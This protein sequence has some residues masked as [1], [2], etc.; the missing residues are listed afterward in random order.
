MRT[1]RY[2]AAGIVALLFVAGFGYALWFATRPPEPP[3]LEL[4]T[5]TLSLR[6]LPPT[7]SGPL[8]FSL[9]ALPFLKG[10]W[11]QWGGAFGSSSKLPEE[12]AVQFDATTR[13]PQAWRVL[14][15]K[16]HFGAVLLTGDPANFRP[17]LEHLRSS[18]DWT[19]TQIDPTS[20]LFQR[21]PARLWTKADLAPLLEI[22]AQHSTEEQQSARIQ[23]AH[24]LL[25]I[26]EIPAGQALLNEVLK[27]NTDSVPAWT[28]MA[29][30]HGMLGQWKESM[31]AADHALALD[32]RY[33]PA[34][35]AQANAFYAMGRFDRALFATRSLYLEAPSDGQILLLHAKVAHSAH[36]YQEEIE[37]LQTMI[38]A[39]QGTSQ[40]VGLLQIYLGQAYAAMGDG[41]SAYEQLKTALKDE[42]LSE[43]DRAFARKA[44][45]R[46][47]SKNEFLNTVP[48]L[49][50]SSLLDAPAGH[51]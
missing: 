35:M 27:A 29:S 3:S 33:R 16:W 34:R 17:L 50:Q 20:Y 5:P 30:A 43:A 1:L 48:S 37:V 4:T 41:G 40:P 26:G 11:Q 21:S 47:D 24:R 31:E 19:L 10:N 49:P 25:F 46:F 39:A 42:S 51:P 12:L 15:R 9:E 36:A 7:P 38:T 14:D 2:F 28:E 6:T 45:E 18:P 8:F 32:S 23:L 44:L 22:F 13:A